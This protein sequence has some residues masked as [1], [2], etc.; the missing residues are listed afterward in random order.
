MPGS[1]P[2]FDPLVNTSR[3][4]ETSVSYGGTVKVTCA[5]TGGAGTKQYAVWY[6]K[7]GASSW[8]TAK[9]YSTT[10]AATVKPK[11]T[12]TY[13]IH[14]KVKDC[15]GTV[16]LKS[17]SVTVKPS[18]LLNT[19][20]LSTASVMK[21]GS[22]TV[23]CSATGGTGTRQYAVYYKKTTASSWTTK[24]SYSD[25]TSVA[26]KPSSVGVYDVCIRVKDEKGTVSK[27]FKTVCVNN[28]SSAFANKSTIS[29]TS[30][31][32]GTK[33][34]L[35]GV[36]ANANGTVLYRYEYKSEDASSYTTV[37]DYS[38]TASASFTSDKAGRYFVRV[39]AKDVTPTTKVKYFVVTVK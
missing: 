15:N 26:I 16:K 13:S 27:M 2:S 33:I 17:F 12:G 22:F 32:K 14:V 6:K 21:G 8:T 24:Q 31:T 4:S 28:S 5:S 10:T 20:T 3:I 19:S 7:S 29:A 34:T 18:D 1:P 37:K 23:K 30:V 11:H 35:K 36:S 9:S 25:T 38:S 39:L